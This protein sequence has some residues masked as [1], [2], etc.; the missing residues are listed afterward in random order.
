LKGSD[1]Q[2]AVEY[3]DEL[4]AFYQSLAGQ[5]R[6]A[7]KEAGDYNA[8]RDFDNQADGC[9]GVIER[10]QHVRAVIE[11]LRRR[12]GGQWATRVTP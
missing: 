10:L 5:Y 3:V 8:K 12:T 1:H 11:D 9:D 7:A 6:Q 2:R 4:N